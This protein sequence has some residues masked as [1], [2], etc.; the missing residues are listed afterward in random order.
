MVG[1]G[2]LGLLSEEAS[3][4]GLLLDGT[5]ILGSDI[6]RIVPKSQGN[7]LGAIDEAEAL[8]MGGSTDINPIP[9]PS[10]LVLLCM[11]ALGFLVY[12][13]RGR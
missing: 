1:N 7:V 2:V 5:E 8:T 10:T 4:M 9:E 13:R 3:L 12:V 6:L 11:G